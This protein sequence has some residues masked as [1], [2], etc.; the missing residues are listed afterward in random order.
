MRWFPDRVIVLFS[1]VEI[2][3]HMLITKGRFFKNVLTSL[4]VSLLS[5][6][7]KCTINEI[8]VKLQLC[9]KLFENYLQ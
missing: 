9:F 8:Q 1:E 5:E 6:E 3:L 4:N 2:D 7:T